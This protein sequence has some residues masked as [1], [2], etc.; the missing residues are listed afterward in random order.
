MKRRQFIQAG[1][2]ASL[3]LAAQLAAWAQEAGVGHESAMP[4]DHPSPTDA[5]QEGAQPAAAP[6]GVMPSGPMSKGP[7]D[8]HE[9]MKR[10]VKSIYAPTRYVFVADRFSNFISVTDIVSGEHIET[11]NFSMRPHVME[12]AR[13]D[14]MLAVGSP[15]VSA[16]EFMNLR[17]RERRRVELPSPVFQIF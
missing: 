7:D 14:A 10:V 8:Q 16:I 3:G 4:G 13:D 9:A 6:S 12:L 2:G 11:L 17:T 5:A 15:E 1:A